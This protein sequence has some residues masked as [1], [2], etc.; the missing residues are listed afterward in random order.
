MLACTC[1]HAC[2]RTV[3]SV[4]IAMALT[5]TISLGSN[6]YGRDKRTLMMS[7]EWLFGSREEQFLL[8]FRTDYA[9]DNVWFC[10]IYTV[11]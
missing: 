8:Y 11:L 1:Y 7:S 2:V 3:R 9:A 10:T 4:F 5:K 6:Y